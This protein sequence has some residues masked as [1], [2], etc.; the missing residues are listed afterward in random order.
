MIEK[1]DYPFINYQEAAEFAHVMDMRCVKRN[2]PKIKKKN[3]QEQ[4]RK[5][6]MTF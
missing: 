6:K 5:C 3:L 4:K 2:Y 1:A